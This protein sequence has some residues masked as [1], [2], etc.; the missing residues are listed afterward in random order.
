MAKLPDLQIHINGQHTFF[1]NQRIVSAYS[2]KLK[3]LIKQEKKKAH[4]KNSQIFLQ[5]DEFPGGPDG[6]ELISSF[7]Y[8]NGGGIPISILNVSA[9]HCGAVFLGMNE[10]ASSC[11]LLQQTE[12]FLEGMFYW[13]WNDIVLCL[14]SCESF[15]ESADS[16][17]VIE[18]LIFSLLAKIA[19]NTDINLMGCS[20]SSSSSSPENGSSDTKN[21]SVCSVYYNSTTA[22][23][24]KNTAWWFDDLSTLSPKI[25]E[26]MIKSLGAYGSDNNSLILTKFLLHYLKTAAAALSQNR[27][28]NLNHSSSYS[29][30]ADTAVYGVILM[31]KTAFSCRGLFWVMRTVTNFGL[32]ESCRAGLE[33]LIGSVLDQAKLD[34]LLVCGGAHQAQA[35]HAPAHAPAPA[36]NGGGDGVYDVNLVVR[37]MKVF[38]G[39]DGLS[40]QRMRKVGWLIDQY[41]GEISPDLNLK[42]FKFMDVAQSLPDVAR[43]SFDGVY[44]AIDIYL[45]SHPGLSS[46]ERSR[47][48]RCL[49]FKKLSLEACKDL[50]KNPRIPPRIAVE[51]LA[52]QPAVKDYNYESSCES[53]TPTTATAATATTSSIS[54]NFSNNNMIRKSNCSQIVMYNKDVESIEEENEDMR[55][56][57]E[58]MQW[59]V[60]ELEKMCREMKGQMSKLVMK[61]RSFPGRPSTGLC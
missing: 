38:V 7:C 33:R 60:M 21:G 53:P 51:A 17:G 10:K 52:A 3:K 61:Q 43:D 4:I 54:V 56:N 25:I 6:F 12:T 30:L 42:V 41:L 48:C 58:K 15:F 49:N 37:L 34:D 28:L 5:I 50:A 31:G 39:S 13:S 14:K 57:I 40:V 9:L 45:E 32:S 23:T 24:R 20:S 44:R 2:V 19:Q 11:N 35:A 22:V 36:H 46:E 29:G 8:N 26:K 55:V 1:L 16:D 47:L 27:G 59:R 18:K